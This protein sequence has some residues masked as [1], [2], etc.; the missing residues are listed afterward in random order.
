MR[1]QTIT[2]WG[3]YTIWH[4]YAL[5]YR[6]TWLTNCFAPLCE[7]ITYLLSFG[8]GLAP[9]IGQLSYHGK[10]VSYQEFIAPA[11]IAVGVLF[12]S[13]FEGA[14]GGFVRFYYHKTWQALLTT[15]LSFNEIF[16]AEWLWAGTKGMIA[17]ILTGLVAVVWGIYPLSALFF[18]LPLIFLG[19]LV[20]G[21]LGL[22]TATLS[23]SI[24]QINIPVFLVVV[25]MFSLCG[26]YFPRDRLPPL[27]GRVVDVLPLSAFVDLMRWP[28]GLPPLWPLAVTWLFFWIAVCGRLSWKRMYRKL[29]E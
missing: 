23:Q 11:M 12:Q 4:R 2:V 18:S 15:P 26:T 29:F 17:G 21:G 6:R 13:F 7:P 28:L 27:M 10:L 16:V 3:V 24:D 22:A 19:S 8:Y 1:E 25:P 20:F 14:Y 5:V 9:L